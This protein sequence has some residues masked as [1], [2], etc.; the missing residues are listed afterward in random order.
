MKHQCPQARQKCLQW[1]LHKHHTCTNLPVNKLQLPMAQTQCWLLSKCYVVFLKENNNTGKNY[2]DLV[3]N[4]FGTK[5]C[6]CPLDHNVIWLLTCTSKY[7]A[8]FLVWISSAE[9]QPRLFKIS[10]MSTCK[11]IYFVQGAL[12]LQYCTAYTAQCDMVYELTGTTDN[13]FVKLV[14][15]TCVNTQ[16]LPFYKIPFKIIW[17]IFSLFWAKQQDPF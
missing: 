8:N 14:L 6:Q 16:V 5:V 2:S 17:M 12:N 9:I 7:S 10:I 11:Y 15:S 3:G 1:V 4:V 13:Y